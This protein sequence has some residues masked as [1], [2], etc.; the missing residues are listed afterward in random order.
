MSIFAIDLHLSGAV[1][2]PMTVLV[3]WQNHWE[4]IKK[5]GRKCYR[6]DAVLI[7]EY[8]WAMTLEEALV[9]LKEI[10]LYLVKILLKEIMI[11]GGKRLQIKSNL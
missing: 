3:H 4:K 5:I 11:I 10:H 7:V 2:K 8:L 9:D 1:H 6:E